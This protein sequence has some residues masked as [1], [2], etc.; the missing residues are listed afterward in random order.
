MSDRKKLF[1]TGAAGKVGAALRKH[2]RDRYD[3]RLL[4]HKTIP[5]DLQPN[6]EKVVSDIVNYEAMLEA[7]DGVDV[8][9]HLAIFNRWGG[10]TNADLSKLTFDVDMKSTYYLLE[11]ARINKV[12]TYVYAS[13]NHVTGMYEKEE[14]CSSIDKPI[15]PDSIYGAGKAF[16]EAL[17][18][19]Y[20]DNYGIRFFALRIANFNGEDVPGRD[21]EPGMSRWH[22]PKDIA[23]MTWRCIEKEELKF[24]IYYGISNGGE[25]KW[26]L[27]NA[28]EELG[29]DPEDDGS[30]QEHREKYKK[31]Q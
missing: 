13:T 11:A 6:E 1:V 16:G 2:L 31:G 18:R 28:I 17:G 20:S 15:R 12:P 25:K 14:I 27:S 30:A 7:T 10:M 29:Y 9:V 5:D 19:Y 26:D 3:F 8:I 23:Q 21:Y 24:G 22:S 4:F